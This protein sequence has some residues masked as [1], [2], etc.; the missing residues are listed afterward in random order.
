MEN[1]KLER[2]DRGAITVLRLNRPEVLNAWRP[3]DR[4]LLRNILAALERDPAVKA[5][6]LTGTGER[7]FC[8]GADLT[9]PEI[10]VPSK[11]SE[12]MTGI[13]DLYRAL[14]SF[15]KPLVAALNG[16]AVGS[17]FQAV[18]LMD[19]SIAHRGVRFAMTELVHGMPCLTGTTILSWSVGLARARQMVMT[20][21]FI[22]AEEALALGLIDQIVE[23]DQ[24]LEA[25]IAAAQELARRA[26][27]AFAETKLWVR[28]LRAGE[29]DDAFR[30]ASEVRMKA[31]VSKA[32]ETGATA[33]RGRSG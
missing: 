25:A 32:I 14:Q 3:M 31:S 16:Q 15:P 21:R 29:L 2:E 18:M 1:G 9:D 30:R 5:V 6:V 13:Q 28:D 23:P 26:P 19:C 4:T 10:S 20:G 7:A 24:V 17:G 8:A 11:A 27:A 33:F 12:R 22:Y